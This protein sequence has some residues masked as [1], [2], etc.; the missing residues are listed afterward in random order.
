MSVALNNA[1]FNA[2]G[3]Q[4]NNQ[5]LCLCNI[6]LRWCVPCFTLRAENHFVCWIKVDFNHVD[7]GRLAIYVIEPGPIEF[8][9][10]T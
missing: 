6:V 2:T 5:D 10:S 8:F 1:C 9:Q 4:L 7:D 3:L